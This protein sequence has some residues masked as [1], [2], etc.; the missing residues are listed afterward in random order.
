MPGNLTLASVWTGT[1]CPVW[2]GLYLERGQG[3]STRPPCRADAARHRA[4]H[5]RRPQGRSVVIERVYGDGAAVAEFRSLDGVT[6]SRESMGKQ[7]QAPL[8]ARAAS[9]TT[10]YAVTPERV[11]VRIRA[12]GYS[13]RMLDRWLFANP[14]ARVSRNSAGRFRVEQ[15]LGDMAYV[16]VNGLDG[17][18]LANLQG[19]AW[20]MEVIT[21]RAPLPSDT[22]GAAPLP[23][24]KPDREEQ[25]RQARIDRELCATKKARKI[26]RYAK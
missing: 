26:A 18:A 22:A 20:V 6:R 21:S 3:M 13:W 25:H 14:A 1:V 7:G 23:T 2:A 4:R 11:T 10:E 19:Q 9:A 17:A 8:V 16:N 5:S 24:S 12:C 15:T